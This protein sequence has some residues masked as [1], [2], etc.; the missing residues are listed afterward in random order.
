[1]DQHPEQE[2]PRGRQL[3]WIELFGHGFQCYANTA[4]AAHYGTDPRQEKR[5]CAGA[6]AYHDKAAD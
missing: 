1:E 5:S 3:E 2:N 6:L 4:L